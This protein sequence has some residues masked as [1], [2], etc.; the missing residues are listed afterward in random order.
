M[1]SVQVTNAS[2]QEP[3]PEQQWAYPKA[4]AEAWTPNDAAIYR[5]RIRQQS[6][7]DVGPYGF[8]EVCPIHLNTLIWIYSHQYFRP[9][10]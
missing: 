2:M 6:L 1:V 8:F 10:L 3:A 4:Q 5:L 9:K 7:A